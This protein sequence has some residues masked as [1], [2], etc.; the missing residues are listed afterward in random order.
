[1]TSSGADDLIGLILLINF[2]LQELIF[3]LFWIFPLSLAF[4]RWH[5]EAISKCYMYIY[6]FRHFLHLFSYSTWFLLYVA[7]FVAWLFR[8]SWNSMYMYS[9]KIWFLNSS[10]QSTI[11]HFLIYCQILPIHFIWEDTRQ[12]DF[13]LKFQSPFNLRHFSL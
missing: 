6:I 13:V 4:S 11:V 7:N 5:N 10:H 9:T 1:M 2:Q 8:F 12:F 3:H